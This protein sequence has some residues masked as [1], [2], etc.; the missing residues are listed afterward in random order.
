MHRILLRVTNK[1][2]KPTHADQRHA[3]EESAAVPSSAAVETMAG[4]WETLPGITTT[5]LGWDFSHDSNPL[6]PRMD[7][8]AAD[9]L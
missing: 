2:A 8:F 5:M 9:H 7:L 1:E 3:S 6:K 4:M